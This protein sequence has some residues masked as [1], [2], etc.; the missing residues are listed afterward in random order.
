MRAFEFSYVTTATGQITTFSI[1]DASVD[2]ASGPT[3]ITPNVA[4]AIFQALTRVSEL[5][6]VTVTRVTDTRSVT[7]DAVP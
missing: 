5:S 7:R 1:G 3:A 6:N 2:D 4:K